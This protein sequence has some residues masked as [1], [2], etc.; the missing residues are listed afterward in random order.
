MSEFVKLGFC[1]RE[2]IA[3][4]KTSLFQ[5]VLVFISLETYIGLCFS[6]LLSSDTTRASAFESA[7]PLAQQVILSQNR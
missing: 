6:A 5:I 3:I 2:I 7:P 4:N 1:K